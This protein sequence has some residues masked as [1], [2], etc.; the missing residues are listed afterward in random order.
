MSNGSAKFA[1][2]LV[3]SLLAGANFTAVAENAAKTVDIKTPDAKTADIKPAD[4]CLSSPKGT[5]PT[6]SHWFYHLDRTTKKQCW[7]LGEA[8]N[9]AAKA[10]T[11][12]QQTAPDAAAADAIPP[13]VQPQPAMRKSVADAHAEVVAPS[14]T[15]APAATTDVS[16]ASN[17]APDASA[18]ATPPE[19]TAPSSPVTARWFDASSMSG[20]NGTRLAANAP[21]P[22]A[23]QADARPQAATAAPAAPVAVEAPAEKPSS[24]STQMLL[25]VMV[26]A[27]ALAGLVSALVFRQTRRRSPPYEIRDE[28]RA[29]WDSLSSERAPP[30]PPRRERPIRLSDV[31]P[32]RA[33]PPIRRREP[34]RDPEQSEDS[35]RQIAE[36]LK[37][38]A[39]TATN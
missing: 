31:P 25:I 36:M 27:L 20:S 38:L 29:P 35:D 3:A 4:S 34:V 14:A 1:A 32:R 18:A 15:V 37:R 6:G 26:G 11:A 8:R 23:T 16:Y 19:A 13:Q 9:K 33:E 30:I 17:P 28:W 7:Y 5:A 24:S 2:A 39:R 12:Q 10:A 21:P 22:A